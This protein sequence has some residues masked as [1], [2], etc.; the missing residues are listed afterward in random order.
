MALDSLAPFLGFESQ[1]PEETF[2]AGPDVLWSVGNLCYWVIECKNEATATTITKSYANQLGGSINW[3]RATYDQTCSAMPLIIHPSETFEYAATPAEGTRVINA[4][5][6]PLLRDAVRRF[7]VGA[8]TE[9]RTCTAK[10][11]ANLLG[12]V[13]LLAAQFTDRFSVIPR[14]SR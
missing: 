10:E 2:G 11:I 6:L 8:S 1:R 12:S 4:E 7:A 3:F 9:F 14:A 13:N 5:K